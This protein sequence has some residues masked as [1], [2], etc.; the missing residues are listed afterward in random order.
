MSKLEQVGRQYYREDQEPYQRKHVLKVE[1]PKSGD[2]LVSGISPSLKHQNENP[3]TFKNDV[4]LVPERSTSRARKT[5]EKVRHVFSL[6]CFWGSKLVSAY[7]AYLLLPTDLLHLIENVFTLTPALTLTLTL[8]LT[9][10]LILILTLTL[11]R[12][13]VFEL[14]KW[15]HFSMKCNDTAANF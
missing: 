2:F 6:L 7:F 10:T 11:K 14:T 1:L 5:D 4:K 8:P 9:V 13:Y 12:N 15:R 3:R